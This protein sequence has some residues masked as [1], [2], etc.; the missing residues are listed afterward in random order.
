MSW[1]LPLQQEEW[2]HQHQ[3]LQ[4]ETFAIGYHSFTKTHTT[5]LQIQQHNN[6]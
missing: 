6:E 5:V 3:F 4:G 2:Q 1:L